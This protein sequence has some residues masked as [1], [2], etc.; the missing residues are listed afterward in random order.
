MARMSWPG[1]L[2]TYKNKDG[3]PVLKTVTH[4]FGIKGPGPADTKHATIRRFCGVQ[5]MQS[6]A[7]IFV[8]LH[9]RLFYAV[10]VLLT[11][12]LTYLLTSHRNGVL[13]GCMVE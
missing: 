9:L 2:V 7:T 5:H 13:E 3:L 1:W 11:Y 12:F 10:K 4:Q 8:F 6:L